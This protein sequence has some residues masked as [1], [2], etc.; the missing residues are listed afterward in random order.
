M[1][2]DDDREMQIPLPDSIRR[3]I[4]EGIARAM[5]E[6]LNQAYMM[7]MPKARPAPAGAY[8]RARGLTVEALHHLI[9]QHR[10]P[11]E[12]LIGRCA[13]KASP[14]AKPDDFYV[15]D[16]KGSMG[17]PVGWCELFARAPGD[18][19]F[20]VIATEETLEKLRRLFPG[21]PDRV[22]AA[23]VVHQSQVAALERMV[24]GGGKADAT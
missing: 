21:Q 24:N 22:V 10:K 15:I 9:D 14:F 4:A 7:G 17:Q 3:A 20:W 5:A 8:S 16:Q 19:D 2:D 6:S 23:F 18:P 11:W 1:K 13:L 12:A